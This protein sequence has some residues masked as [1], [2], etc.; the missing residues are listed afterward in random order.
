MP[1]VMTFRLITISLCMLLSSVLIAVTFSFLI[2]FDKII[3]QN[4]IHAQFDRLSNNAETTVNALEGN[5][6]NLLKITSNFYEVNQNHENLN[7][8]KL[9][10]IFTTILQNTPQF[11]S[12]YIGYPN[13]SFYEIVN[14]D[15]DEGLR[16]E[17]NT[18]N[19]SEW[20]LMIVDYKRGDLIKR[21]EILDSKFNVMKSSTTPSDYD[22]RKRPWYIQAIKS[23]DVIKTEP[24]KFATTAGSGVTYALELEHDGRV[25][26]M[27]VLLNGFEQ[28]LSPFKYTPSA[29]AYI[30]REG[31]MMLAGTDNGENAL[32]PELIAMAKNAT[33]GE[34]HAIKD[35]NNVSHFFHLKKMKSTQSG[36]NYLGMVAPHAEVIAAYR[37]RG[38]KMLAACIISFLLM[39]PLLLYLVSIIARPIAA[40]KN[41]SDKVARR[42]FD[43][44]ARIH[45]HVEEIDALSKS[46]FSMS[47]SIQNYERNLERKIEERTKELAEKNTLLQHLSVTDKLTGLCNRVHLDQVLEAEVNHMRQGTD[48]L[49]VIIVDIDH[50]KSV[51][52]QYGHQT[53]DMVLQRFAAI[54]S[55]SVRKTDTAGRWGGEEFLIICPE[56]NADGLAHLAEKLRQNVAGQSFPTV[57]RKT[58]SFGTALSSIEDRPEDLIARADAALYRAKQAGRNR[59]DQG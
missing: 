26:A 38:Y 15:A 55:A 33:N 21:I 44:V 28:L 54:I 14:L 12:I 17:H 52:D 32:F 7:H 30:W 3:I 4:D 50:F 19:E 20:L 2:Y 49:G 29:Q 34:T 51:N 18:N 43:K 47:R 31:G 23:D 1:T 13:G 53:G 58:A 37:E 48:R 46:V 6:R 25:L 59:V 39:L 41:D 40:I 8:D 11:Y 35:V 36:G 22:P 5:I 16:K 45:T 57:G 10:N 42:E 27:D 56:T 24:Y 9:Q